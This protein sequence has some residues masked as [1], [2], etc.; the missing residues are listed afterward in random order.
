MESSGRADKPKKMVNGRQ[1]AVSAE[2]T[3]KTEREMEAFPALHYDCFCVGRR[4]IKAAVLMGRTGR[5]K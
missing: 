3:T 4:L 2:Q 1:E 5:Y